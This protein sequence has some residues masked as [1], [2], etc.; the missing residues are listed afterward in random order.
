MLVVEYKNISTE[1]SRFSWKVPIFSNFNPLV[2]ARD[3]KISEKLFDIFKT[4]IKGNFRLPLLVDWEE[5]NFSHGHSMHPNV[6]MYV[7]MYVCMYV[8]MCV[9]VCV[10]VYV[11]MY[12]RPMCVRTYVCTYVNTSKYA[13]VYVCTNA[14]VRVCIYVCMGS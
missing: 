10:C 5:K 4:H 8:C 13:C 7:R 2:R 3:I 14:C 12:C 9:C 11:C 6:Y 1:N